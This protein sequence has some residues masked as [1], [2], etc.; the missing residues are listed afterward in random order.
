MPNFSPDQVTFS[1]LPGYGGWDIGHHREHL[2]F[3]QVLSGLTPAVVIPD[4]DFLSFLT[5]GPTR[6]AQLEAHQEAHQLLAQAIGVTTLDFSQF[7]IDSQDDFYSFLGYHSST[8][9][10]I[11]QALGIS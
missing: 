2:Q 5:A 10:Q 6:K 7:N 11:R 3:V 8:H 9:Q 4:Y 1:D